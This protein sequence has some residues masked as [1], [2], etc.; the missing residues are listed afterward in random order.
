MTLTI[1]LVAM[2]A[3]PQEDIRPLRAEYRGAV[4]ALFSHSHEYCAP[5]RNKKHAAEW[6][7]LKRQED[8]LLQDAEQST[9]R[10]DYETAWAKAVYQY[11]LI[12]VECPAKAERL[13]DSQANA[14]I[15]AY[16]TSLDQVR[17]LQEQ[18]ISSGGHAVPKRLHGFILERAQF[19]RA[20]ENIFEITNPL[21]PLTWTGKAKGKIASLQ[22]QWIAME[23][24][25]LAGPLQHD[26]Y[27]ATEDDQYR[28]NNARHSIKCGSH[29]EESYVMK[30]SEMEIGLKIVESEAANAL[31][32]MNNK[33][34]L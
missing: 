1:F 5:A 21:C 8:S 24:R 9:A 34:E 25:L 30:L 22:K 27:V 29:A 20:A 14:E 10:F 32:S 6:G 16:K 7:Q 28:K 15:A 11:Q 17:K 13:T 12:R 2:L 18:L 33:E 4:A 23:Q 26:L 3:T 31:A 19:Q